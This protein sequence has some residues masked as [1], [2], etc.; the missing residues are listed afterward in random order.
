MIQLRLFFVVLRRASRVAWA[1]D[2]LQNI[3]TC[4]STFDARKSNSSGLRNTLAE[5]PQHSVGSRGTARQLAFLQG[6][7]FSVSEQ[8]ARGASL[9]SP[10]KLPVHLSSVREQLAMVHDN[11]CVSP[12]L[13][14][15]LQPLA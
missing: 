6:Q 9:P 5:F 3:S 4:P 14:E 8:L 10:M 2:I 11:L 15:F 7:P 13:Q 1:H 12:N